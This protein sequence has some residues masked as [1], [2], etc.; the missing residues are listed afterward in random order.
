MTR[1]IRSE[2]SMHN[3]KKSEER[4]VLSVMGEQPEGVIGRFNC[5]NLYLTSLEGAPSSV[6]GSFSCYSN[7][8]TS[9]H[10]IHKQIK[11]IGSFADLSYNPIT[12]HVLGLLLIDGLKDVDNKKVERIINIHLK[13]GRDIFA[14]QE[15]LIEA[16]LEEYAQL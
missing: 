6:G 7:R 9:L 8:L 4:S 15:E 3:Y 16:G 1:S 10:N 14:C 5:S 11:Y 12:S 2:M 13:N